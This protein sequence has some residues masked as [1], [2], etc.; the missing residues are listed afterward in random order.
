MI[1]LYWDRSERAI[2][3]TQNKFGKYCHRIAF[4]ILHNREDSEECVSD[5][6]LKAWNSIP[7]DRPSVFS[8]YLGRI[9]RNLAINRYRHANAQKRGG[10][11]LPLIFDELEECIPS[12]QDVESESS[13]IYITEALN[14]FLEG[15]PA[16]QR[17]VFVRR[18]WYADPIKE[19]AQKLHYSESKVKSILFQCRKRLRVHLE[20]EGVP[21]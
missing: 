21:V 19:I 18:Y 4:N 16:E 9:T 3:E 14:R 8:A 6:C 5:T 10:G 20:K 2:E 17:I 12:I 11:G 13:R 7:T 15:L 1:E